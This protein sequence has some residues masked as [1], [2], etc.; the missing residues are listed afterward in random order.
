MFTARLRCRM[1]EGTG[2]RKILFDSAAL[3]CVCSSGSK[4]RMQIH[5]PGADSGSSV[6]AEMRDHRDDPRADTD[7]SALPSAAMSTSLMRSQ[8]NSTN[9]ARLQGWR[10]SGQFHGL[11]NE[12]DSSCDRAARSAASWRVREASSTRMFS[13][14]RRSRLSSRN[15]RGFG[16]I[17]RRERAA[18]C[19]L[20]DYRR[21]RDRRTTCRQCSR[22]NARAN[23]H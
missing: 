14:S 12:R 21:V 3:R 8:Q 7:F 19:G 4:S 2:K 23:A 16:R 20:A 9:S 18:A 5:P 10:L 1:D 6:C 22:W 11:Q 15:S 13:F 17:R